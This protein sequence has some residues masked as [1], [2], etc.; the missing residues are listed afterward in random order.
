MVARTRRTIFYLGLV[1]A[2]TVAFTLAYNVGLAVFEGREQ[3]LYR[4]F[5]VVFQTFTTTGYGE[6][7]PWS[8]PQMNVF[9]VVMQLAGIGLILTAVDVFAVP[10]LRS[11]LTPDLPTTVT[12]VSDHV[13]LCRYTSR[14]EAFLDDLDSRGEPSVVI[15]PDEEIVRTL[16]ERDQL[17]IHGDPES[18]DVL[19]NAGVD[20]ARAVV[21]DAD[22][23]TNASIVLSVRETNPDL[24]VVTLVEREPLAQY[25]RIAGADDVLSPRQ[26]LG[27]SLAGRV[28]TAVTT[29]VAEGVEIGETFELA[30]LTIKPG[31]DLCGETFASAAIRERFGVNVIGVWADGDFESP[32]DP[33]AEIERGT[34][35]LVAGEADELDALREATASRIRPFA[36]QEVVIAGFGDSGRAAFDVLAETSADVTVLDVE[37]KPAVDVVG[38]A[39]D[40]TVL[41]AA[42]VEEASALILTVGD[43]TT[44]IFATLVARDLNPDV[45]ILV[46]ANDQADVTKL[47]RAGADYV[48]SLATVGGRM[49]ASTVFED[50]EILAF[51]TRIEIVRLP[52]GSLAGRTLAD[53]AVRAET[54]CTIVAVDRDGELHRA[55]DPSTFELRADDELI[56]VGTDEAIDRFESTFGR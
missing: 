7:A 33:A 16:Q 28:P 4:S 17:V 31:S 5:E 41:R 6:D 50:E 34:T 24:R 14:G 12:D 53:A 52:A 47:S 11:A 54:G 39:R 18:T 20:E 44:A 45:E 8:S 3:P 35:L 9:V 22:D 43:D 23:D 32:A 13:V 42:G 36:A 29:T 40:P 56:V 48:Q 21:A 26:L 2:T 38:D 25:H 37:S 46:R 27:E 19:A 1:V 10:W 55:F 49:M 30:E 15:E 51:D